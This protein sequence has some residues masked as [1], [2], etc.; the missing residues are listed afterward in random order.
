MGSKSQTSTSSSS[1]TPNNLAGLQSIFNQVQ[2]AAS[3][4][5]QAYNGELTAGINGQQTQGINNINANAG[6]ANPFIQS[7]SG[8][9]QGAANPLTQ[10]QIQNYQNPYTQSVIDATQAQFNNQNAIQQNQVK[11]NA[12]LSGAL[13]GDRQAVAQA[14]TAKNQQLAQAP[15]IAGLYDKGYQ[16]ALSTAAQQYQQNPLA[17]AGALANFGVQGQNAAL[18]GAN[19]Q[20][21][22][23]TLQQNAQQ[24]QDTAAYQQYLQKQGYPF[25]TAQFFSQ[26]GLP[27]ALGQGSTSSGTQTTPGPNPFSQIAGLGIAGAGL[28]LKDGGSVNGYAAGGSPFNFIEDARGYV[29]VSQ[30]IPNVQ[31]PTPQLQFAKPSADQQNPYASTISGLNKMQGTFAGDQ[32][33]GGNVFTDA[34]GGSSDSPLE[35]LSASD[36]GAGF[37]VGG[38]VDAI[39][40]IRHSIKRSRGG[41]VG[42]SPFAG[43]ADGGSPTFDDRFSA[44]F[45]PMPRQAD[46]DVINPD[47]PFRL[48]G[49]EAMDEWRK[50]VDDPN[51]AVVA[52]GGP[53][54]PPGA[55]PMPMRAALPPQITNP[56]S[57]PEE[58]PSSALAYDAKSPLAISPSGAPAAPVQGQFGHSLFGTNLS[59]KTRQSLVAA[60]LGM[61]ASKSPFF[62]TA[63]GEG[64]LNGIGEYSDLTKQEQDVANQAATKAQNQQR[65]D[66]EAKRLSQSAEQFTKN[67]GLAKRR[68][69][70]AE[71]KTPA[72][73][74]TTKEGN[75]E[76]IPG[77]P[78]DPT[79]LRSQAE[80]KRVANAVLDDDTIHDMADQYLAGDR[81][82]MQNLGRGAQG[83]ENI[84]KLRQ[85]IAQHARSAGVDPA[86]IVNKFNEQA[87]AL[88]GQRTV[89]ARAANISLAANEANNMIPIA[90]EAS[91]KLPRTQYM[92]WNQM[93]QTVQKGT[94]SP[95]LASFVA[96]TNSLVNS[97]V[98]A[99]SPSGVPTDA[100]R[101]HAYDMLNAAQGPEAYKAVVATMQKEMQAALQAPGQVK[102]ELRKGNEPTAAAMPITG[103]ITKTIG[104]KT[105]VKRGGQWFEQ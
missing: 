98:R 21:G 43:Y 14:E 71:D 93:V 68:V 12:A 104:N 50:S 61:L 82:V 4:P 67:Y 86:G 65:I 52:D 100:M 23:G 73:Y 56:D 41:T 19:A 58:D 75:Y 20:I 42:T 63:L 53:N 9:V 74:R 95:E 54:V 27:S 33:G 25:Q 105:Y 34:S 3:T 28:F 103:N 94:S 76:P 99:V 32:Y 1:T 22:A 102:A 5:Y 88:A 11:G 37:K 30:G 92:P 2:S 69:D 7:A 45:D 18:S 40:Q 10:S 79:I 96:A 6:Y 72:G 60:G 29:P 83:A 39:H 57:A 51:P 24:A 81:T 89:G 70:L 78:A 48:A 85:A 101:Q 13:G 77:G 64:G 8:L 80:A 62:G 49:P 55:S 17:Q 47:S 44:A 84:V 16:N 26:Y 97:Y 66:M 15:V 91:D 31:L 59:D 87:G 90:L 35:G 36:Y 38:F 46:T